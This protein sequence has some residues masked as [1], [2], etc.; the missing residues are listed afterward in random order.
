MPASQHVVEARKVLAKCGKLKSLRAANFRSKR[1][2][3]GKGW[4]QDPR[5]ALEPIPWSRT[6]RNLVKNGVYNHKQSQS[7]Q[8]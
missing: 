5:L 8:P 2:L 7:D 4:K 1:S 3:K 6:V